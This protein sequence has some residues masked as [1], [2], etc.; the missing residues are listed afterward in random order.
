MLRCLLA[1]DWK[2]LK[3]EL[4]LRILDTFKTSPSMVKTVHYE[5]EDKDYL[6]RQKE[7][8]V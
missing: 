3:E 2:E 1:V 5:D 8:E 6:M 4:F 7:S